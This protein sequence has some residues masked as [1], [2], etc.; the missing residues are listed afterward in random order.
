VYKNVKLAENIEFSAMVYVYFILRQG[1]N[2]VLMYQKLLIFNH[3]V[4]FDITSVPD[5]FKKY[6]ICPVSV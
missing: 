6:T 1:W 2:Q 3:F 4:C 5:Y